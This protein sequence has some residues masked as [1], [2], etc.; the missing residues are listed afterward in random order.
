MGQFGETF[1]PLGNA[2]NHPTLG[3]INLDQM[4]VCI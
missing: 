2:L 1:K 3:Y 4:E